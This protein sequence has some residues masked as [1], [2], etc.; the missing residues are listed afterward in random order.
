MPA[1]FLTKA[2]GVTALIYVEIAWGADLSA[3]P[4]TW[5]WTDITIDVLVRDDLSTFVGRNEE[6]SASQSGVCD[7]VLLNTSGRYS[8]GAQS[9]NYPNVVRN[10][11]VRVRVDPA[12]ATPVILFQGYSVGFTPMWNLKGNVPRVKLTISGVLRRLIQ[13]ATPVISPMR[14]AVL[15][16]LDVKAYWPCEDGRSSSAVSSGL[17]LGNALAFTGSPE[18]GSDTS[19]LCSAPL[20]KLKRG[21]LYGTVSDYPAS[22]AVQVR[23]LLAFPTTAEANAV[24]FRVFTTGS[25]ARWDV[26]YSSASGGLI[27]TQVYDRFNTLLASTPGVIFNVNSAPLARRWSLEMTQGGSNVSY[28]YST[29]DANAV[30]AGYFLGPVLVGH[31]LGAVTAVTVN[32]EALLD[33]VVA[34]HVT[35]Q[36]AQTDQYDDLAELTGYAGEFNI[37]RYIRILAENTIPGNVLGDGNPVSVLVDRMGTQPLDTV[38]TILRQVETSMQGTMFDGL[39]PGLTLCHRYNI[40][41]RTPTVVINAAAFKLAQPFAPVDDDQRT[42]NRVEAKQVNGSTF[43]VDQTVGPSAVARIG[44]YDTTVAVNCADPGALPLL[45][46][47]LVEQGTVEGYRYPELTIDLRAAPELASAWLSLRPGMRLDVTGVRTVLPSHPTG[48]LSLIVEGV[49]NQISAAEWTGTVKCS[50]GE[51]WR[52][53]VAATTTGDVGEYVGRADTSGAQVSTAATVNAT[54][55]V[56]ATTSGPIWT[57]LADDYPLE[58]SVRGVRVRATACTGAGP[59][60]FTVDP[61]TVAVTIGAPVIMW[62]PPRVGL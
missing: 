17:S 20:P 39:G 42:R 56:V 28:R 33:N 18:F 40:E 29:L 44:V 13:G 61:L 46:G 7:L 49:A 52:I 47:W 31:T 11:P 12:T 55:L 35:V 4:L 22:G 27:S 19:F 34:G 62:Q 58:L 59:Q 57:T 43:T 5:V 37:T 25:A 10:T 2:L 1:P 8:L 45:A 16:R 24:V 32:P 50:L 41:N 54:S 36:N 6:A 51:V 26:T 38:T 48:T 9:P 60:T 53:N 15:K 14:R 3:D 21:T 23:M 30:G